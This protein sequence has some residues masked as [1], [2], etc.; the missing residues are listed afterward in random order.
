M[1]G[2]CWT[3][4]QYPMERFIGMIQPLVKNRYRPYTN[5]VNSIDLWSRFNHLHY[6]PRIAS[7]LFPPAIEKPF[8]NDAVFYFEEDKE[9]LW[10]PKKRI[11][12]KKDEMRHLRNWYRIHKTECR[13]DKVRVYSIVFINII[14]DFNIF[15]LLLDI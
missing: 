13:I 9:Q 7:I 12:L 4:W 5:L 2:P 8:D 6:I 14:F 10:W 15:I 1:A 11:I 3:H